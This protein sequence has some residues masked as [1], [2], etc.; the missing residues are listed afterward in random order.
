MK[1][2]VSPVAKAKKNLREQQEKEAQLVLFQLHI[3]KNYSTTLPAIQ[4]TTFKKIK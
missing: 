3:D 4:V 1:T 2:D